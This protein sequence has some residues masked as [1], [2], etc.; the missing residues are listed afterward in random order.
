MKT[1]VSLR[2]NRCTTVAI[3]LLIM[4]ASITT[5]PG[6]T[7]PAQYDLTISAT[8]GGEITTPGEGTFSYAKGT[9]VPLV[10]LPHTGYRFAEWTGDVDTINDANAASTTITVNGHY[11]II[12]NFALKTPGI[13]DWYDLDAARGNLTGSYILMNDLDS[14]TPGYDELAGP[15]ANEG[16]GW[17]PIGTILVQPYVLRSF[18]GTFD[19][20][21]HEIRDLFINRLG[22]EYVGLFGIVDEGGQVEDISLLNATVTG[23]RFVGGLAG[24]NLGGVR[25]SYSSSSVLGFQEVGCLIG[26]NGGNVS[27]SYSG[28][29]VTGTGSG[30]GGLIGGNEG[31]VS[32]SYASGNV[33]GETGA[34]WVGGLTGFNGGT[35]SNSCSHAD[36]IGWRRVGGLVGE[37]DGGTLSDCYSTGSVTSIVDVGGLAG[38]NSGAVSN[39]Y[40]SGNVAADANV[41]VNAGGL[42]GLNAA[43]GS[44]S[45]SYST[46]SVTGNDTVGGLVASNDGTVSNSFWDIETSGQAT[47]DGGTGKT[48][49]EIKSITTFAGAD[50]DIIAVG[51]DETN[52]AYIWN[53]VDG[54]TYPFLS[55][56]PVS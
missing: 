53:I 18:V 48:T 32:N 29:N 23:Y 36:V 21:G 1:M 45:N 9:T 20:Q 6:C 28:C 16:K 50:W 2:R 34:R 46:G 35:V 24:A 25:D 42:V 37:N 49:V 41:G 39:C 10:A 14:T 51:A 44:V 56:Q 13:R 26:Y 43:E 27:S 4:V 17:E 33:T 8:E 5:M 19:G 22:E 40:S 55:W 30:V 11:E 3:V 7:Q 47:S 31:T 54:V 52:S 38:S 12:A 15:T